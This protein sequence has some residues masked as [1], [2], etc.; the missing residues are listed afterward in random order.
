MGRFTNLEFGREEDSS[1]L[2]PAVLRKDDRYYLALADDRFREGRFEDALRHYARALEFDAHRSEAWLGQVQ[3]LLELDEPREARVWADKGLESFR[4]QAELLAAKGVAAARL[5]E[6]EEAM[7][8]SDAALA[9]KGDSAYRWRARGDVLLAADD[10]NHEHCFGKA[11]AAAPG[12]WFEPLA[13]GRVYLRFDRPA[14]ALRWLDT[15]LE[16]NA[17]SAFLW[18]T[19]GACRE[20]LGMATHAGAA[21]RHAADLDPDRP[22]VRTALAR[23]EQEG[24]WDAVKRTIARWFRPSGPGEA[25]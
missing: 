9:E 1:D 11:L 24:T 23:L 22:A 17:A 21:Y 25:R 4:N 7:A 16:R 6:P 14:P 13:I 20:R 2:E 10:R 18:E 5:G 8:L 19:L 3:A 12:D 15:A